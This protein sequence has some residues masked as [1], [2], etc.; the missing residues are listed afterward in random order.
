[1]RITSISLLIKHSVDVYKCI[2]ASCWL[3]G[4]VLPVACHECRASYTK[5]TTFRLWFACT[6]SFCKIYT[7]HK[8]R[9]PPVVNVGCVWALGG[10][11]RGG[12]ALTL[13]TSTSFVIMTMLKQF[14]CH[15]ILQKSYR[16]SCLGPSG[17]RVEI[18]VKQTKTTQSKH[19]LLNER[20]LAVLR[21]CIIATSV[22]F[23]RRRCTDRSRLCCQ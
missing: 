16:V 9:T 3:A 13:P 7:Y 6:A 18:T 20:A 15:T 8:H 14:S 12:G 10:G 2:S 19:A 4:S 22:S 21:T 17:K 11:S 1:M 5:W 23:V